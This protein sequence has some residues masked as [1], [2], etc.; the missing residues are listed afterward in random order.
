MEQMVLMYGP[1]NAGLRQW[2][3]SERDAAVNAAE[4]PDVIYFLVNVEI[5]QLED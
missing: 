4:F 1:Y 3:F 2:G 5:H